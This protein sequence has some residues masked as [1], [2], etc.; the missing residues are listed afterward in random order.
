MAGR[1]PIPAFIIEQQQARPALFLEEW[2]G[3]RLMR[4]LGLVM[5]KA[6]LAQIRETLQIDDRNVTSWQ[7]VSRYFVANLPNFTT[8]CA[9]VSGVAPVEVKTKQDLAETH[10]SLSM[11]TAKELLLLGKLQGSDTML[12]SFVVW[13]DQLPKLRPPYSVYEFNVIDYVV[14]IQELDKLLGQGEA[15]VG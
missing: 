13:R 4:G 9:G 3:R 15:N 11:A 7:L 8:Q 12:V 5:N 2:A 14:I 1:G 10:S 6:A